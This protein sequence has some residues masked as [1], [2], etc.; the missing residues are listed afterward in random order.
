MEE[1]EAQHTAL[2]ANT[3]AI[4][5]LT[6]VIGEAMVGFAGEIASVKARLLR[7]ENANGTA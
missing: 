3:A 2:I 6:H 7:L 1:I 4:E 5:R